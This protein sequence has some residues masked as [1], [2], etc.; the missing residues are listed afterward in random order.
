MRETELKG[1][2]LVMRR[3]ESDPVK[4]AGDGEEDKARDPEIRWKWT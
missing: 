1:Y 4:L 3:E 2:R